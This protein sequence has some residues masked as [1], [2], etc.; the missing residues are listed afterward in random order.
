MP[1]ASSGTIHR[2]RLAFEQAVRTEPAK[3]SPESRAAL[4]T[5]LRLLRGLAQANAA[6]CQRRNK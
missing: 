6:E 3:L 4:A 1:A 2:D 5:C